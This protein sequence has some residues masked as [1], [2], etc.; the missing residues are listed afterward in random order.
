MQRRCVIFLF[1]AFAFAINGY[2]TDSWN[3]FHCS[4]ID[5][6]EATGIRI[7]NEHGHEVFRVC[8]DATVL[9]QT[10][11]ANVTSDQHRDFLFVTQ[12]GAKTCEATLYR[13]SG[14]HYVRVGWWSGWDIRAEKWQNQPAIHYEELEP[15]ADHPKS[16]VY[17]TWN[18]N[19]LVPNRSTPT[20]SFHQ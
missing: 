7:L 2:A 5:T 10:R 20:M 3:V 17:F 16:V 1:A 19:Q 11:F 15:T 9:P 4:P 8:Q 6:A 13:K 18:G 12:V 14:A